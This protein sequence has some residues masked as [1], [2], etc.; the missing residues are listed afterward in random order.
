[1][2]LRLTLIATFFSMLGY[3]QM[4]VFPGGS[5][6]KYSIGYQRHPGY[7]ILNSGEKVTGS[8]QYADLEFPTYNL[9]FYDKE[10]KLI[11]RFKT[12]MIERAVFKGGDSVLGN[13]DS[14]SFVRLNNQ[15][16]LSRQ[17]THGSIIVYDDLFNVNE[18]PGLIRANGLIVI[19]QG[20]EEK[21]PSQDEFKKLIQKLSPS[22]VASKDM[23]AEAIIRKLNSIK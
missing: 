18:K 21:T 5:L 9:K 16:F 15:P 17:L 10:G 23:T 20:H 8:F 19:S 14:T 4:H 11:K 13:A 7:I 1:M 3:A 12:S 22:I 2:K 6:A